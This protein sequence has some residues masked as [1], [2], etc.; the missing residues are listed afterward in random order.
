MQNSALKYSP[1]PGEEQLIS[2]KTC[3]ES[4]PLSESK[5]TEA[6]EYIAYF[7]GLECYDQWIHQQP[8]DIKTDK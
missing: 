1:L 7:C 5:I 2:C 3:L 6:E 8:T 4:V